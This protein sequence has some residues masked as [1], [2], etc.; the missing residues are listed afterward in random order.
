MAC[1]GPRRQQA[2]AL[3]E[4]D[5]VQGGAAVSCLEAAF[6]RAAAASSSGSVAAA[7]RWCAR[8]SWELAARA[9][10]DVKLV[11]GRV[12]HRRERGLCQ[13]WVLEPDE[14]ALERE[15]AVAN[16]RRKN[17]LGVDDACARQ[18]LEPWNGRSRG[19]ED[20]IARVVGQQS[21]ALGGERREAVRNRQRLASADLL[22]TPDERA[23]DLEGVERVSPRRRLDVP[24]DEPGERATEPEL[25]QPMQSRQRERPEVAALDRSG[26]QPGYELDE[27]ILAALRA[28]RRAPT[29][30]SSRR[31][32]A[33][34]RTPAELSSA[35]C[36]SST[37]SSSG[38]LGR[39]RDERDRGSRRRACADRRPRPRDRP[40]AV[41]HRAL[42]AAGRE[43]ARAVPARRSRRDRQRLPATVARRTSPAS[44][45]GCGSHAPPPPLALRPK[46]P[47]SRSRAHLRGRAPRTHPRRVQASR[48]PRRARRRGR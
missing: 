28:A 16:C 39:E 12:V 42:S 32:I 27:L 36:T 44:T 30:Q 48:P 10:A 25:E 19:E 7:P 11:E 37:A 29:G 15:D 3:V 4:R 33:N 24:H 9:R 18:R 26:W 21:E 20:G 1:F 35:H 6:S 38:A 46:A 22:A 2:R 8:A 5:G 43:A 41:R 17:A 14:A 47:S 13:E 23:P 40:G 45:T 34:P 31:R